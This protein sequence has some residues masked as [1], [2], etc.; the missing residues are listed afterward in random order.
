MPTEEGPEFVSNVDFSLSIRSLDRDELLEMSVGFS[1]VYEFDLREVVEK[2]FFDFFS[3]YSAVFHVW[4]YLGEVSSSTT[5]KMGF[6]PV[7]LD[8]LQRMG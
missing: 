7:Y 1:V 4:P 6:P 5:Q 2:G 3:K 8:L